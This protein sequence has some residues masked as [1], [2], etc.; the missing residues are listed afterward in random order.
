MTWIRCIEK[1]REMKQYTFIRHAQS[2]YNRDGVSGRDPELTE[3]GRDTAATL[4]GHYDYALVSCMKRARETFE[5]APK[6]TAGVVEYS[7]LCREKM[8]ERFNDAN[9]MKGE[10]CIGEDE[11][12]FI[13]RMALLKRFLEHRGKK[14]ESILILCHQG[15]I[16]AMTAESLRNGQSTSLHRL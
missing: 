14:Y 11:D 1:R 2:L 15:V 9:L 12:E 4:E 13:Y 6:L 7:S 3:D 16:H 10:D 5:Y 8:S